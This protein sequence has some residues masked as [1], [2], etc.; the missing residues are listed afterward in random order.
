[1]KS[2]AW[3][4]AGTVLLALVFAGALQSVCAARDGEPK[5]ADDEAIVLCRG[6]STT[7]RNVEYWRVGTKRGFDISMRGGLTPQVVKAG[8][9]YLHTYSTIYRNVFAPRFP[10]P[11]GTTATFDV[12]AGGVTYLGDLTAAPIRDFHVLKWNF[13]VA[14]RPETLLE[15]QKAFPWLRKHPLYVSKDGG[16]AVPVRWSTDPAPPPIVPGEQRYAV[17]GP[18]STMPAG[19]VRMARAATQPKTSRDPTHG[20]VS[21]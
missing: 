7:V 4:R 6:T 10:E 18:S 11:A 19:R 9:Y 20:R 13:A 2:L 8:R 5:L 16:E 15:A 3:S 21:T 1:V 17:T 14:L 12:P